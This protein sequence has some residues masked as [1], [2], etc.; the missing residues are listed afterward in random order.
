MI[1][2]GGLGQPTD[3]PGGGSYF[4]PILQH[5]GRPERRQG[6]CSDIFAQAAIDF[7]TTTGD[8]PFFAYL[9]FNCAHEPLEAPPRELAEYQKMNLALSEFPKLAKPIP[10]A[11]APTAD[12][13]SRVYAMIT[14]I[15][16]NVGKVLKALD[17]GG[18]AASTIVIFMTDNGPAKFRFNAGL[19]G[20]KGSVYDG[21]I[22]VPCYVRWPGRFP[23]GLAV[24]PIAAHIDLVPTLLDVCGGKPP[25][26]VK[27]DGKS[28]L[29]LL[30]GEQTAGW[31][32]R[33][34]YFQ[35]HRG[36]RPELGRAFAARSQAYKL[37][38][39]EPLPDARKQPPLEL[40]D[41]VHD[42]LELQNVAASHPEIVSKLYASYTAWFKDVSAT[43]GFDPVRIEVR[44]TRDDPTILTRQ[45][46]RGPRAGWEPNDLGYWELSV[47]RRTVR[48]DGTRQAEAI[49]DQASRFMRAH[50]SRAVAQARAV[51]M[52]VPG[53]GA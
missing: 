45:D 53:L 15:D 6:Y 40:Y 26:R 1:K 31:P 14:N 13:I 11:F 19:R 44:G 34:L 3:P 49:S 21:G 41:M 2:G 43:R 35:W 25:E 17:A 7:C 48:C 5:N 16:A 22:H 9:A 36:D 38:R 37:V 24:D 46:W 39:P 33:T 30:T 52:L 23:A 42:P 4:D 10:P 12:A 32:D 18:L 50:R 27:L 29:P 20:A 51:R 8:R 28:L 47:P